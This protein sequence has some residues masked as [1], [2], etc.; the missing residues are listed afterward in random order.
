[1]PR[2]RSI[3]V[4]QGRISGHRATSGECRNIAP[5]IAP[6]GAPSLLRANETGKLNLV[7]TGDDTLFLK[8]DPQGKSSD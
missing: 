5:L 7:P 4:A 3:T 6:S 1:M 8:T 2:A